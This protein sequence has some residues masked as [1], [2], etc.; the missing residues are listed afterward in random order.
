MRSSCLQ[1][2]ILAETYLPYTKNELD[3]FSII[4]SMVKEG[5]Y[6]YRLNV[7][8]LLTVLN[9]KDKHYIYWIMGIIQVM[10]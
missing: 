8:D 1:S 5:T 3:I 9:M 7:K 4:L 2:G 6:E 10:I